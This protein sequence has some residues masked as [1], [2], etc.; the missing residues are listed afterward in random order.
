M[1][2]SS[3]MTTRPSPTR[4]APGRPARRARHLEQVRLPFDPDARQFRHDRAPVLDAH[5]VREAAVGLEEV[6]VALVAPEPSPAGV[7]RDI[8]GP[9]GRE[10]GEGGRRAP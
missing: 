2:G 4:T 9:P 8:W 3:G 6:G 1:P 5:A 10:A 7:I